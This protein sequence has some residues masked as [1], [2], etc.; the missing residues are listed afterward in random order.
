MLGSFSMVY[1][2]AANEQVTDTVSILPHT[3]D[4][5]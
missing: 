3:G 2:F 5:T 1:A 4:T